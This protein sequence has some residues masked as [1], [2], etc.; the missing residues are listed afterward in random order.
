M[1]FHENF[2]DFQKNQILK[3]HQFQKHIFE[4]SKKNIFFGVE[5]KIGYSFD[6]EIHPLSIYDV[7][8][9]IPALHPYQLAKMF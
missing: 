4:T 5:K 3:K 7:F 8:R 9:A 2:S 1:V 6:A